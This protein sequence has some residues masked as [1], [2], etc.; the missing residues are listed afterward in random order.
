MKPGQSLRRV[1]LFGCEAVERR[2]ARLFT[3]RILALLVGKNQQER[4]KN[5][6]LL[7]L[8]FRPLCDFS[9]ISESGLSWNVWTFYIPGVQTGR[10]TARRSPRV[11]ALA[12]VWLMVL[13]WLGS[14]ALAASPQ[15]HHWVHQD[16][17]NPSH[18]CFVTRLHQQPILTE[19]LQT[20][21]TAPTHC[22][23]GLP[24][25]GVL[26]PVSSPEF[27]YSPSRAPPLHPASY[28]VV[29]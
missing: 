21:L 7:I 20:T 27:H 11:S 17:D 12:A 25:Y 29:G 16:S 28:W 1:G 13:L 14:S 22:A 19:S 18:E 2:S 24:A 5:G 4:L 8:P 9:S 15:L 6:G 26:T 23:L 10:L 3:A